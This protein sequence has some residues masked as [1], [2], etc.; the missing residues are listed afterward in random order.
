MTASAPAKTRVIV[1]QLKNPNHPSHRFQRAG[2][3]FTTEAQFYTVTDEQLAILKN[4]PILRVEENPSKV[5]GL[6]REGIGEGEGAP[7]GASSTPHPDSI[8]GNASGNVEKKADKEPGGEGAPNAGA[9]SQGKQEDARELQKL[10]KA[11][12]VEKLKAKGLKP[13]VDFDE[14]AK[15]D[16][17]IALLLS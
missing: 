2:F 11:D 9:N 13:D 6:R 12:I 4:E 14:S 16:V 15:I 3:V 1:A 10:P 8:Q 7:A 5:E 17:L